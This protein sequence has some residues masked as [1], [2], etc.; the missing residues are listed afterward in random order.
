MTNAQITQKLE[1]IDR[2]TLGEIEGW[3]TEITRHEGRPF[4]GESAA[5]AA[6][7]KQLTQEGR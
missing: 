4:N 7:E 5:L 3:R 6:R 1:L 2:L